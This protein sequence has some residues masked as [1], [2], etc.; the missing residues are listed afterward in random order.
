MALLIVFIAGINFTNFS[1]A[2]VPIRVRSINTQKILGGSDRILRC[3]MLVEAVMIYAVSFV[4][5][6]FIVRGMANTWLADMISG[7]MSLASNIPLLA[8]T[9]ILA[10]TVG[11]LAGYILPGV[12]LLFLRHWC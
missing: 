2:L 4:I 5:S 1:N 7:D 8:L 12:S 6:L 10:I 11:V 3:A 9:G